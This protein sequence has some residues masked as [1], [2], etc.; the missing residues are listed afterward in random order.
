MK[1]IQSQVNDHKIRISLLEQQQKN[2][3]DTSALLA[4]VQDLQAQIAANAAESAAQIAALEQKLQNV[5]GA[6]NVGTSV[7]QISALMDDFIDEA[8]FST[9][10]AEKLQFGTQC[11]ADYAPHARIFFRQNPLKTTKN[12]LVSLKFWLSP[13]PTGIT[14]IPAIIALNGQL[15]F[16]GSLNVLASNGVVAQLTMELSRQSHPPQVFNVLEITFFDD[17]LANTFLDWIEVEITN[18]HNCIIL[19]RSTDHEIYGLKRTNG[20]HRFIDSEYIG[21]GVTK[22]RGGNIDI[23]ETSTYYD[24][25]FDY[26]NDIHIKSKLFYFIYHYNSNGKFSFSIDIHKEF[27]IT[28]ENKLFPYTTFLENNINLKYFLENVLYAKESVHNGIDKDVNAIC[29]VYQ[30]FGIKLVYENM[31]YSYL[32]NFLKPYEFLLNQEEY[33]KE[34]VDFVPVYDNFINNRIGK[35][36]TGYVLLHKSGNILFVPSMNSPYFI[37]LGKGRQV[38][39]FYGESGNEIIITYQQNQSVVEK[40][41]IRE[42]AQSDWAL[43][44][45]SK[46]HLD[47]QE[48]YYCA[49]EIYKI[50]N[51]I[52]KK[53]D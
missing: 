47:C 31:R 5:G 14:S 25:Y 49:D 18:S 41:L 3:G 7:A 45:D 27:F 29:V 44:S 26:L 35:Q 39:A 15:V 24:F 48:L 2:A 52:I 50:D 40:R 30:D 22:F 11:A 42:S 51:N 4:Q 19:N 37:K 34:F 1:N 28:Q 13:L 6:D 46:C 8:D 17:N 32:E 23:D 21:A 33:P 12:L 38:H 43:S 36:N 9:G 20:V 53:G 10:A 16:R